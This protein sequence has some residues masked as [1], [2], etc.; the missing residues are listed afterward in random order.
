MNTALNHTLSYKLFGRVLLALNEPQ[1]TVVYAKLIFADLLLY[2]VWAITVL[3]LP[4]SQTL[5]NHQA[6]T[7]LLIA[8]GFFGVLFV[9]AMFLLKQHAQQIHSHTLFF[10]QIVLMLLHSVYLA[11]LSIYFGLFNI[12]TGVA[13]GTSCLW[14]LLLLHR[15]VACAFLL[16]NSIALFATLVIAQYY[17]QNYHYAPI[18]SDFT[19]TSKSLFWF[20]SYLL[21]C[22]IKIFSIIFLAD[23]VFNIFIDRYKKLSFLSDYD[24]LTELLNR[25][26]IYKTL[27]HALAQN[28][29]M[30]LILLDIDYFKKIN[31]EHGHLAGDLVIRTVANLLKNMARPQD[32]ASRFNDEEY[33]LYLPET[34]VRTAEKIAQDLLTAVSSLQIYNKLGAKIQVHASIGVVTSAGFTGINHASHDDDTDNSQTP[35]SPTKADKELQLLIEHLENALHTAKENGRNQVY[36][37]KII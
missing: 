17:F 28:T 12:I 1:K 37:A 14:V 16:L 11:I 26:Y 32:T 13:L 10:V 21:L 30:S 4:S 20:F 9:T 34:D 24:E 19:T 29:Q 33:L 5:T 36:V 6:V 7:Q 15:K 18:F 35:I 31:D 2:A 23:A 3:L 27:N 8:T 25:Q 22:G